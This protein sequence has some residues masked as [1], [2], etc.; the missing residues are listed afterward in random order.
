[1]PTKSVVLHLNCLMLIFWS[2]FVVL[3]SKCT[4]VS[5]EVLWTCLPVMYRTLCTV[6]EAA[7]CLGKTKGCTVCTHVWPPTL[8]EQPVFLLR[9]AS[10]C[11]VYLCIVSHSENSW[12]L[13]AC[14]WLLHQ[15]DPCKEIN[16]HWGASSSVTEVSLIRYT[17]LAFLP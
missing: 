8:V 5:F 17:F 10:V 12:L 2:S 15:C 6:I 7:M 9:T 11:S 14:Y 1:M 13:Q 16:I 3:Y 4:T